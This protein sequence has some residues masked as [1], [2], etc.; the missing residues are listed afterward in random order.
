M[1]RT[2]VVSRD[3][4]L[5]LQSPASRARGLTIF[6]YPALK[7]WAISE[8]SAYAGYATTFMWLDYQFH[9]ASPADGTDSLRS[10]HKL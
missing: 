8:P 3:C 5:Y 10:L 4:E 6:A 2:T 7:C 9:R 1:K